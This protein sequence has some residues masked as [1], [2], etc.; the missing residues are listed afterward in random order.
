[1]DKDPDTDPKLRLM[2]PDPDPDIFVR[3]LQDINNYFCLMIGAG[4]ASLT[5]RSG[6]GLGRPKNISILRIRIR[7]NDENTGLY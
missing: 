7:N 3:D 5:N 6:C 1:M 4:S 2:D